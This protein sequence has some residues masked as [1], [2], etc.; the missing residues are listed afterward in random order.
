MPDID[1]DNPIQNPTLSDISCQK[2][3]TTS[4]I[5][6]PTLYLERHFSSIC[7]NIICNPLRNSSLD[8]QC[9]HYHI[10]YVNVQDS[11]NE[12]YSSFQGFQNITRYYLWLCC[13]CTASG[14]KGGV[15]DGFVI[16]YL[17]L[18]GLDNT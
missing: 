9:K 2:Y 7:Y 6:P 4:E 1:N 8:F 10:V 12:N 14:G 5:N 3:S 18:P 17:T 11:V 15:A 16:W 13:I